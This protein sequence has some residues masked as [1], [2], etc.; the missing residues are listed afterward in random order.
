MLALGVARSGL[1]RLVFFFVER[2]FVWKIKWIQ[3]RGDAA[4]S[5]MIASQRP[6]ESADARVALRAIYSARFPQ[7]TN[8][9]RTYHHRQ[10]LMAEA[11][12]VTGN[13]HA[14]VVDSEAIGRQAF[15]LDELLRHVEDG[16]ILRL[17]LEY[18]D[19]QEDTTLCSREGDALWKFID[20]QPMSQ[21]GWRLDREPEDLEEYQKMWMLQRLVNWLSAAGEV[22]MERIDATSRGLSLTVEQ[23]S[24]T[25]IDEMYHK[26]I[27][28]EQCCSLGGWL[29]ES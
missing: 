14:Q 19:R 16:R 20:S 9:T 12:G 10:S 4:R 6:L 27:D 18:N 13:D 25:L 22:G 5:T 1:T 3:A 26:Y 29:N 28:E 15:L 17:P 11:T 2:Q 8:P 21:H 24:E 23:L 7:L